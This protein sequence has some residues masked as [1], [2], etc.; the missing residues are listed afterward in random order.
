MRVNP[1]GE[2]PVLLAVS[3]VNDPPA[4][5][6]ELAARCRR[7]GIEVPEG[8]NESDLREI[9]VILKNWERIVDA[10]TEQERADVLNVLL[11]Q[12][13]SH[14]SLT[15]HMGTGWH[16]HYR[17]DNLKLSGIVASMVHVGTALLLIGR[18]MDRLG[19]CELEG[20]HRVF[21]DLSRPGTKRHCSAQCANNNAV[22]RHRAH[23]L[24]LA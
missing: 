13:S 3:L 15:D 19:R 11:A 17:P 14:P 5:W 20:C 23:R 18:G 1:Y 2:D 22:R 21:V 7:A 16:L 8:T 4:T 24:Q 10:E 12:S 9:T 6:E